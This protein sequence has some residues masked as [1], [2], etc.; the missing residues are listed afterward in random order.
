M[1]KDVLLC[2]ATQRENE[3]HSYHI[4]SAYRMYNCAELMSITIVPV[5]EFELSP[6]QC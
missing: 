1:V 4:A 5:V 6:S 2:M 3:I